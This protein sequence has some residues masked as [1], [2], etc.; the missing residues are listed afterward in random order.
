M[1]IAIL[2]MPLVTNYG[3]IMQAYA[4]KTVLEQMGHEVTF[5]E[6]SRRMHLEWW[7]APIV[8]AYRL[9]KKYV[10]KDLYV[11][12]FY[13]RNNN[14]T[15]DEEVITSQYTGIFIKSNFKIRHIKDYSDI[16]E[17]DYDVFIVGS[18]QV[19][20]HIYSRGILG[21][22][23]A[24]YLDFTHDW[25]IKRI[26]YAASFGSDWWEMDENLTAICSKLLAKFDAVSVREEH[27][28]TMCSKYLHYEHAVHVLDPTMLLV[29]EDYIKLFQ[30]KAPKS[31]GNLLC[32][33]LDETDKKRQ[34]IESV[35]KHEGL[36]PFKV[37]SLAENSKAAL[38]QRIQPPVEQWLRGFYD[39]E[40]IITDSFHACV[41]SIL[42]NKPF[43]AI[44]NRR[45]GLMRFESL[46]NSFGLKDRMIDED[47]DY[48]LPS[49]TFS[50][51]FYKLEEMKKI[52]LSFLKKALE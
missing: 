22:T 28:V 33:I 37:N 38:E 13:E 36:T 24:T 12:L 20:R 1:K 45:R 4:L 47:G 30:D 52:S 34:F 15:L 51:N 7:K 40:F 27:G 29:K 42:F 10:R 11:Q 8:Y 16:K 3:A 50:P 2:T 32:Y 23:P 26:S 25:N 5:I 6:R 19:W 48:I 18:D 44:L 35:A 21:S 14:K 43:V 31:Q 39:A 41:F 9:Y 46:L 17:H 49:T